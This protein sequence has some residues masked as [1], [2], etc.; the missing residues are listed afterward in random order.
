[1]SSKFSYYFSTSGDIVIPD[2]KELKKQTTVEHFR[3]HVRVS[4]PSECWLWT[5][6]KT[7]KG[8]GTLKMMLHGEPVYLAHRAAWAIENDRAING[9]HVLHSCDNPSCCNPA[10]LRTGTNAD[11]VQDMIS[12]RRQTGKFKQ[13][14]AEAIAEWQR[15]GAEAAKLREPP[16]TLGGSSE[17]GEGAPRGRPMVCRREPDRSADPADREDHGHAHQAGSACAGFR[18]PR[19]G[20]QGDER[21]HRRRSGHRRR[22][23]ADRVAIRAS[24][25]FAGRAGGDR[26]PMIARRTPLKRSTVPLKRTSR[27][28]RVRRSAAGQAKAKADRAWSEAV[29][30]KGPCV[31][32]GRPFVMEESRRDEDH[33]YRR[34]LSGSD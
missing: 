20:V 34:L 11:N 14:P 31:A 2:M 5:G 23:P 19:R 27:P 28:A 17:A 10:H 1:M 32:L 8:Y 22:I 9:L 25:G 7:P 33:A 26:R 18:Q 13:I 24:E 30:A 6:P 16:R 29:K 15:S 4:S 12:K 21:W 3:S